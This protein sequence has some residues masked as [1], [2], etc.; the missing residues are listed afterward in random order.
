MPSRKASTSLA[1]ISGAGCTGIVTPVDA[2]LLGA[3]FGTCGWAEEQKSA[4]T[5]NTLAAR[6][7]VKGLIFVILCEDVTAR[8]RC[9]QSHLTCSPARRLNSSPLFVELQAAA[10]LKDLATWTPDGATHLAVP[11]S[12]GS[13]C[14]PCSAQCQSRASCDAFAI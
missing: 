4:S 7:T 10:W 5:H 3:G 11:F 8:L 6:Q 9:R 1:V 13:S 14:T 2:L 12:Q